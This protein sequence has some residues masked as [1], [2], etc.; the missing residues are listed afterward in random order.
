MQIKD[1]ISSNVLEISSHLKEVYGNFFNNDCNYVK[2]SI[3]D[4]LQSRLVLKNLPR[5]DSKVAENLDCQILREEVELAMS[6]LKK[7]TSPGVDGATPELILTIYELV[8]ALIVDFVK[9]FFED[10]DEN[11]VNLLVKI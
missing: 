2:G 6:K 11:R 4:F 10:G 3:K 9:Y 7:S 8:P 5:F 1:K